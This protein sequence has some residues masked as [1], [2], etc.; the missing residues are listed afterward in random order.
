MRP[1][2]LVL[3]A[4]LTA[5]PNTRAHRTG[6]SFDWGALRALPPSRAADAADGQ[7]DCEAPAP[8][9][10]MLAPPLMAPPSTEITQGYLPER[11]QLGQH[12]AGFKLTSFVRRIPLLS[13]QLDPT[14]SSTKTT[15]ASLQAQPGANSD[16][17]ALSSRFA[18]PAGE[19][20]GSIDVLAL[21]GPSTTLA[22]FD[23]RAAETA[24]AESLLALPAAA[25]EPSDVKTAT[26]IG[27][28]V[29]LARVR[30]AHLSAEEQLHSDRVLAV[31]GASDVPRSVQ[32]PAGGLAT[33]A[34]ARSEDDHASDGVPGYS[35]GSR[36][37]HG[38]H[39]EVWR[40]ERLPTDYDRSA[41]GD[42]REEFSQPTE[43]YVLKRIFVEKGIDIRL[44][45]LREVYFGEMLKGREL[46]SVARYVEWFERIDVSQVSAGQGDGRREVWIVFVD[47]G[48]SLHDLLYTDDVEADTLVDSDD[49]SRNTKRDDRLSVV[50]PSRLWSAIKADSVQGDG[51]AMREILRQA[52]VALVEVHEEGLTHR[53]VKPENL[54][55]GLRRFQRRSSEDAHDDTGDGRPPRIKLADFGSA[56][57]KGIPAEL[58]PPPFRRPSRAEETEDYSSPEVRHNLIP[59]I[60]VDCLQS[61]AVARPGQD[62]M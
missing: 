53:D 7:E 46:Q 5:G 31:L 14:T 24:V 61:S 55:V 6:I 54:I 10:S 12:I 20:T 2:A 23:P 33:D 18:L 28:Q 34:S 21:P 57:T 59:P 60:A 4:V 43:R 40:A 19:G 35:M 13:P 11:L 41:T 62:P 58:W 8:A 3:A 17:V 48:Q 56:N 26:A 27:K 37:G 44:S 9:V 1:L 39:G 16:V 25:R 51:E 49:T 29:A 38:H 47:E 45:G 36:I 32:K 42:D 52:L 15:P 22:L 50:T 30:P